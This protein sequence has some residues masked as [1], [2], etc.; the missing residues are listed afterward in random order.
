MA[1]EF[2]WVS[3]ERL[4]ADDKWAAALEMLQQYGNVEGV[5]ALVVA[6]CDPPDWAR[7]ELAL[8]WEG[9]RPPLPTLS[10]DDKR[11]LAAVEA[12]RKGCRPG[13]KREQRIERIAKEHSVSKTALENFLNHEGG[14][15]RRLVRDWRR[16][17]QVYLEPHLKR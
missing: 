7:E 2:W 3:D 1:D 14:T 11:L 17:E 15:Y 9:K 5:L 4:D 8:W 16:W 12:Y 6:G 10:E 13:E